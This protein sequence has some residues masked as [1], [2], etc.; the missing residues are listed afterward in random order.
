ML[1]VGA[2]KGHGVVSPGAAGDPIHLKRGVNESFAVLKWK[3]D[4][5]FGTLRSKLF[6]APVRRQIP[7]CS[8]VSA[9][10]AFAPVG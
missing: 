3:G 6:T 1:V 2:R 9:F 7:A 5:A 10:A 8:A 4:R